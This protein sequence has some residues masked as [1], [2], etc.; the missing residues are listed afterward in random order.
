MER[1][2]T[3]LGS[4]IKHARIEEALTQAKLAEKAGISTRYLSDIENKNEIPSLKVFISLI[5][6]LRLPLDPILYPGTEATDELLRLF[7]QCD[8]KQ[9]AV[10]TAM[11]ETM[12]DINF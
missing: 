2:L 7:S 11:T 5:L 12:I 4:I 6:A 1:F 3:Q 9:I 8:D 10:I